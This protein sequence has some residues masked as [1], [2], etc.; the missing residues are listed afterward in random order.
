MQAQGAVE[1]SLER[2][3]DVVPQDVTTI[4]IKAHIVAP[5]KTP[6]AAL[7]DNARARLFDYDGLTSTSTNQRK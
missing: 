5:L 7:R 4:T 3:I 6:R 2:V 1:G